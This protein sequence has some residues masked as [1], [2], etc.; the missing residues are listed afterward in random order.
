MALS[1]EQMEILGERLVPMFQQFEGAV[2]ADVAHRLRKTGTLTKTAELMA[3]ELRGKGFSPAAIRAQVMRFIQADTA[4]QKTIAENTIA[5]KQLLQQHI[6]ELR[7]KVNPEILDVVEETGNMAFNND[8]EAWKGAALPV[9][10]SAFHRLVALMQERATDEI[11]NLTKSLGFRFASGQLV[12]AQQAYTHSL[13]M[14]MIKLSSGAYSYQQA[15]EEAV[16]ELG[17]SGIRVVKFESGVTRQADTAVRNAMLTTSAQLSG[18]ITMQNAE[19]TGVELVEVSSH[20]GARTGVGHGNHAGWQG[21]IYCIRGTDGVHENLEAA[22]GYPS[23]PKGLH[24]YNCRHSFFP[25]WAGISEPT[26]WPEEPPPVEIDGHTYTYYQATQQQRRME[27]E[28]RALKREAYGLREAGLYAK[29]SETNSRA[30]GLT[31]EYN[32]FSAA[33]GISPKPN[34]LRVVHTSQ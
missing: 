21:K 15:M 27:R 3:K 28:I 18:Q 5:A 17:R 13:N 2:I 8:L 22:T 11:M 19:D 33:A 16:R 4:M 24:G 9:R 7:S 29:A 34:R 14:V 32:D 10:G 30:R 25:F 1:E 23:D 12:Q 31:Q 26:Q 6:E 20:W